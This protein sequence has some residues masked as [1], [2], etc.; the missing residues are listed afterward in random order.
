[1]LLFL[2]LAALSAAMLFTM[3]KWLSMYGIDRLHAIVLNYLFAA[4]LS[5]LAAPPAAD[6][7][8]ATQSAAPVVTGILFFTVFMLIAAS[9][10]ERGLA[11]TTTAAKMSVVIPVLA[12]LGYYGER[13]DLATWGGI[14][15]ALAGVYLMVS[16]SRVSLRKPGRR[17]WL[18]V[19]VFAGSGLADTSVKY[20]QHSHLSEHGMFTVMG[21]VFLAAGMAGLPF[22]VFRAWKR[23]A[24]AGREWLWGA[25][26]GVVNFF[27]LFFLFKCL[28][29]P[30]ASSAVVFITLNAGVVVLA[31]VAAR[32][33]FREA[34]TGWQL[35]GMG[36]SVI[37]IIMLSGS[38]G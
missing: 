37:A 24:P 28:H 19:A 17:V 34:L 27:S 21:M 25:T 7:I 1:M 18:P 12:G 36:L 4:A 29:M 3:F 5:F 23:K 35:A 16:R 33:L 9:T 38:L 15:L 32:A 14:L 30:G 20:T 13:A 6:N 8:P 2:A 31:V 10:R 26:F 11:V 22:A